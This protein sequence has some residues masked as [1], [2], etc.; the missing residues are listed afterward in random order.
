MNESPVSAKNRGEIF[1]PPGIYN[2]TET[3]EVS[4]L[5]GEGVECAATALQD[6][7]ML[8][9]EPVVVP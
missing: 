9:H 4:G 6:K 2:V 5:G 1:L 3:L 7:L 8:C